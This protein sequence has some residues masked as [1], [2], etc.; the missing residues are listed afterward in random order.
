MEGNLVTG[1]LTKYGNPTKASTLG[2]GRGDLIEYR[3]IPG[4]Y[5]I[6]V[7]D[8][9]QIAY[10]GD[11]VVYEQITDGAKLFYK[12]LKE[13]VE[14]IVGR[15][16]SKLG[17]EKYNAFF[18]NCETFA[19]WAFTGEKHDSERARAFWT[20]GSAGVG[21]AG[22]CASGVALVTSKVAGFWGFLG[23]TTTTFSFVAAAP[24]VL[25]AGLGGAVLY[26]FGKKVYD[27][28][29]SKWKIKCKKCLKSKKNKKQFSLSK[30]K[31]IKKILLYKKIFNLWFFFFFFFLY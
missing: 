8:H 28:T 15:A 26:S 21:A 27:F 20:G 7:L 13:N 3:G 10:D 12:A 19:K 5:A 31:D 18:N 4:H 22:V 23:Y 14:S 17:E 6:V 2:L 1:T 16:E 30:F 25:G 29:E 11:C 24:Y 9:S